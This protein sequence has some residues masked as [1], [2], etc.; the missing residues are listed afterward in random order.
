[1]FHG[2]DIVTKAEFV[3]TSCKKQNPGS[4]ECVVNIHDIHFA[5][6]PQDDGCFLSLPSAKRDAWASLLLRLFLAAGFAAEQCGRR[7]CQLRGG[8]L[9]MV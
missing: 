7:C 1:M 8:G 4:P 2:E 5:P 9:R 3:A 6:P